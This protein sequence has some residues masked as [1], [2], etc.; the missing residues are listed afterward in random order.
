MP[1]GLI[2]CCGLLLPVFKVL[3]VLFLRECDDERNVPCRDN[4]NGL[5]D[6]ALTGLT[7]FSCDICD[8]LVF[9]LFCDGLRLRSNGAVT[10]KLNGMNEL[11]LRRSDG[12]RRVRKL[13]DLALRIL[14]RCLGWWR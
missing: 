2:N 4:E 11:G 9:G 5:F 6:D 13:C 1:D 3:P 8:T 7:L 14:G 10:P 12:E